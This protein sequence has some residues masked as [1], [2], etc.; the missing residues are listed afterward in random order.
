NGLYWD[1][2]ESTLYLADDGKNQL[3]KWTDK[4]GFAVVTDLPPEANPSG[5]GNGQIVRLKDG[6]F[7]I[8]RFG[9]GANGDVVVVHPDLTSDIVP[10]LD[11]VRRRIGLGLAPNGTLYIGGFVKVGAAQQ[12]FVSVLDLAGTETDIPIMGLNKVVGVI[13]NNGSLFVSDQA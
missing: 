2:A 8:P 6:T 1:T 13:V 9:F 12:G 10:N 5:P 7:V 11:P 4:D 3:V